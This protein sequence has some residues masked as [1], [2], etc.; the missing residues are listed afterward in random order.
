MAYLAEYGGLKER[1]D[2]FASN[3]QNKRIFFAFV[4]DALLYSIF[5]AVLMPKAAGKLRFVPFAGLALFLI[6]GA[7]GY[8]KDRSSGIGE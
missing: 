4:L 2:Y 6:G 5:Q 1:L 3:V 7:K 8:S